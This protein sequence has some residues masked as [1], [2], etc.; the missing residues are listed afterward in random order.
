MSSSAHVLF[1]FKLSAHICKHVKCKVGRSTSHLAASSGKEVV[2]DGTQIASFMYPRKTKSSCISSKE[3]DGQV[4]RQN[5][6][7]YFRGKFSPFSPE[8]K[9]RKAEMLHFAE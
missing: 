3:R 9:C 8:L 2:N 1:V 4:T 7:V 6:P 5:L